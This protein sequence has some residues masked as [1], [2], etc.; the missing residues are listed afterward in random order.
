MWFF[1]FM[2]LFSFIRDSIALMDEN[3]LT[4]CEPVGCAAEPT[5]Q[6]T[7]TQPELPGFMWGDHIPAAALY[8]VTLA[9]A[10]A[11]AIWI[12]TL[13][14]RA[15]RARTGVVIALGFIEFAAM[16]KFVA[17]IHMPIGLY[18][19][20]SALAAIAPSILIACPFKNPAVAQTAAGY[21]GSVL[22]GLYLFVG[23]IAVHAGLTR[24]KWHLAVTLAVLVL[25]FAIPAAIRAGDQ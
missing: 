25:S 13:D 10:T 15:I 19:I 1:A 3:I 12:A 4:T 17:A 8:V 9:D 20:L 21:A 11:T 2:T 18:C 16:G 7:D 22:L 24:T 23:S 5:A 14:M 6:L